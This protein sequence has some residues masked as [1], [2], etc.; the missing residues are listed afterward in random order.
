MARESERRAAGIPRAGSPS[1]GAYTS[2]EDAVA[3]LR[4]QPAQQDLVRAAYLDLPVRAAAERYAAS[5]EWAA[6][7][8]LLPNPGGTAL[9]V[10]AGNGIASY[11]LAR[12][13]WEVISLE[14]DPSPTVGAAAIRELA[15]SSA[16]PIRVMEQFGESIPLSDAAV[17]VVV[18]RQVLH[19]AQD[20]PQFCREIARVLR[21]GGTLL[22]MRDHVAATE[23]QLAR[24]L[25]EHPLHHRYGGEHAFPLGVY[26]RCLQG[27]GL[28]IVQVL[29]PLGSPINLAPHTSESLRREL[30]RRL[31]SV[32]GGHLVARSVASPAV[33]RVAL[34]LFRYADRR[35]GRLYS[36]LCR[37]M[38]HS[39]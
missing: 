11:A 13:G 6:V 8:Q 37:R 16:L 1:S 9:D 17:D 29:P 4:S 14:P 32:P 18:A 7:R 26:K 25:A 35:P 15:A 34:R 5:D 33:W 2:W 10:G 36:F 28:R 12:D 24:F 23:G 31:A 3:W 30:V 21:P 20:L 39:L 22:A 38:G 27:A 19:H